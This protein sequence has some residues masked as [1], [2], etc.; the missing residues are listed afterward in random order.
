MAQE[1]EA[2][3]FEAQEFEA[4]KPSATPSGQGAPPRRLYSIGFKQ[5]CFRSIN[6][7]AKYYETGKSIHNFA[8]YSLVPKPY[9]HGRAPLKAP[10][11]DAH[12]TN[13]GRSRDRN[14]HSYPDFPQAQ[15]RDML[16]VHVDSR[17]IRLGG[18]H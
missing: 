18:C 15:R 13:F 9:F 14:L 6:L 7:K 16:R 8:G 11:Y 12:I 10:K 17:L 3:E 4:Q 5:L 1:F 2:Q